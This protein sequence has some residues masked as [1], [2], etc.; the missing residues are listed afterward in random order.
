MGVEVGAGEERGVES[1]LH[2][3][4]EKH[5]YKTGGMMGFGMGMSTKG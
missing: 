5:E 1:R 3:G 2:G 4:L